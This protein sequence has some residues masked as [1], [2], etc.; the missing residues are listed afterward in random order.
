MFNH[1]SIVA[2]FQGLERHIYGCERFAPLTK[3]YPRNPELPPDYPNIH[4]FF[5]ANL[6]LRAEM[7]APPSS[8]LMWT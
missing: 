5:L 4:D 2:W 6:N 7:C 8:P 3:Y 1:D